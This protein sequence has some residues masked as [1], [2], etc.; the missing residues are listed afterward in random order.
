[1]KKIQILIIGLCFLLG[2]CSILMKPIDN[3]RLYA[4]EFSK[5]VNGK[6]QIDPNEKEYLEFI[7][8][9]KS[10]LNDLDQVKLKDALESNKDLLVKK[11]QQIITKL[12]EANKY[13][14]NKKINEYNKTM[15]DLNEL[16]E[17]Y[18]KLVEK[19]NK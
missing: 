1:M 9:M 19:L 11:G 14:K 5:I 4:G 8:T 13:Y 3:A 15:N 16:V 7:S 18:N 12:E 17:E 10:K 6:I 2:G